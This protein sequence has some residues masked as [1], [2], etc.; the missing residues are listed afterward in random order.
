MNTSRQR[1]EIARAC[2]KQIPLF[3]L[4]EEYVD[5]RYWNS[6]FWRT[7]IFF[8]DKTEIEVLRRKEDVPASLCENLYAVKHFPDYPS[9]LNAM[10]EAE[11]VLLNGYDAWDRYKWEI[12]KIIYPDCGEID[13]SM[14]STEVVCATAAQR[15][16]AFLRT[17]GKWETD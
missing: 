5:H 9:D 1:I 15:A 7:T 4:E 10:H 3:K 13:I 12:A 16:E 11:K 14:L 17:I 8:E 2:G 6:G